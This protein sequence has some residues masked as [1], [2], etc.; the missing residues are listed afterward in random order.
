MYVQNTCRPGFVDPVRTKAS[1]RRINREVVL[2]A[3]RENQ[4]VQV[5][6]VGREEMR[7]RE[8]ECVQDAGRRAKKN[9]CVQ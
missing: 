4:C 1:K 3:V 5:D 7:P 6:A 9:P 8:S 2:D